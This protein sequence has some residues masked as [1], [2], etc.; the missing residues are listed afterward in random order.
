MA[1]PAQLLVW[2][3]QRHRS[4][5]RYSR[6]MLESAFGA[7]LLN[8]NAK[9]LLQWSCIRR[10]M[11]RPISRRLALSLLNHMPVM[12]PTQ[13]AQALALVAEAFPG[14]LAQVPETWLQHAALRLPAWLGGFDVHA[15][16]LGLKAIG[17]Q[18]LLWRQ[19]FSLAVREA[20][21]VEGLAVVGN[22]ASLRR[23]SLGA[24]VDAC[25]LVVRFNHYGRGPELKPCL[26]SKI[27]VW[28][29]SPAYKGPPPDQV[30]QWVVVTGPSMEYKL[31]NWS[32]VEP[33]LNLGCKVLTVP[34]NVWRM[35]IEQLAAPPSAG[36][37]ML[38][39]LQQILCGNMDKVHVAGL[40]GHTSG[41][42]YTALNNQAGP[43]NRHNWMGEEAWLKSAFSPTQLI[44]K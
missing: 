31:K 9:N 30:P 25:S 17:V 28:V 13:R 35:G 3:S 39:W 16:E 29:M 11:G 6:Q 19:E 43:S 2:Q 42:P 12:Q 44:S 5:G 21:A 10:D 27:D 1:F 40:G 4:A 38:C 20:A 41:N 7:W 18:Q 36:V 34:L 37:L 23:A 22:A 32:R 15:Q 24:P 33:L 14:Y 26:G 8:P